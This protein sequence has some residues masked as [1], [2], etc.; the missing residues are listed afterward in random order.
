MP[1][2]A[3]AYDFAMNH[4]RYSDDYIAD[5]LREAQRIAMVGASR[6]RHR[7]SYFAMKYLIGKGYRSSRS[8]PALREQILGQPVYATLADVPA[9]VDI[10]D[11]FRNSEAALEVTREAIAAR[12]GSAS[13]SCGCSSASAMTLPRAKPKPPGSKS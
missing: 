12:T 5:I 1:V 4:D 3:P 2:T 8:I 13:R 10:V 7:P 9:P 11:I 6:Q